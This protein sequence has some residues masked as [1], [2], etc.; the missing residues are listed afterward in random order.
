[1]FKFYYQDLLLDGVAWFFFGG[2][3]SAASV[4]PQL[5]HFMV[6]LDGFQRERERE[7]LPK[8]RHRPRFPISTPLI[9]HTQSKTALTK[10]SS[11][12]L[13]PLNIIDFV[14]AVKVIEIPRIDMVS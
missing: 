14:S 4:P 9:I 12:Y 13:R 6:E 10:V 2:W 5:N 7:R 1:M 8:S 11:F 3:F